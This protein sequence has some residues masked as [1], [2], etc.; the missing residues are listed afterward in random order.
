L[1]K[2]IIE[3]D[4]IYVPMAFVRQWFLIDMNIK[5][6]DQVVELVSE[7]PL[8]IQERIARNQT[9]GR[10]QVGGLPAPKLPLRNSEYK[11]F[12]VPFMDVQLN[13]QM[14]DN[15]SGTDMYGSYSVIGG[16]DLLNMSANYFVGGNVDDPINNMR[17]SLFR[18]APD[19]DM[20]GPLGATYLGIGDIGAPSVPL[21]RTSSGGRGVRVG[22]RPIGT[23]LNK[24]TTDLR[25]DVQPGWDVEL[26]RNGQLIER[27]TAG[28]DGL[29]EFFTLPLYYGENDF[30]V[31][32]YGPQG[33][34]R[35]KTQSVP[36]NQA[37]V[38]A[39]ELFFDLAVVQQGADF[40][41]AF[42]D[43]ADKQKYF[44]FSGQVEK[45]LWGFAAL[46]MGFSNN[47]FKDGSAHKYLYGGANVFYKNSLIGA[48]VVNDLD[49]G[50]AFE[51]DGTTRLGAH[52]V[53][54]GYS[55]FQNGF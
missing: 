48:S 55:R 32:M 34:I 4:D 18:E 36:L 44:Q 15:S 17:L 3:P 41:P 49:G 14:D 6:R 47:E 5:Y 25:G 31:I 35:E 53:K 24:E 27:Q 2:I 46:S 38:A 29:Y 51:L 19:G 21:V 50:H 11:M 42:S 1:S 9:K 45:N 43:S 40:L 28:P 8:P 22:N 7:Y 10:M 26:Y 52:A 39:N 12:A 23:S 16:G 33:Q 13:G 54:L 30:K 37:S 20:L